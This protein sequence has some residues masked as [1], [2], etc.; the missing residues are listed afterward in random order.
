MECSVRRIL[1]LKSSSGLRACPMNNNKKICWEFKFLA[2]AGNPGNQILGGNHQECEED[3]D[4]NLPT[5]RDPFQ[6]D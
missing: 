3:D 5:K 2:N 1:H 6:S 4:H